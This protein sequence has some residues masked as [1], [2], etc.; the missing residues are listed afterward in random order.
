M[1]G[2]T[3]RHHRPQARRRGAEAGRECSCARPTERKDEFLATLAHE[4]RNPLAPIRNAVQILRRAARRESQADADARNDRAAGQPHGALVDDLLDV[5]RISRGMVTLRTGSRRRDRGGRR[6]SIESAAI[7]ARGHPL[8]VEM[9]GDARLARVDPLRLAQA[10]SNLLN[11]AAKYT[12]T[13]VEVA[14]T[15]E[16][17]AVITVRDNGLGLDAAEQARRLRDVLPGRALPRPQRRRPRPRPGLAQRLVECTA[18]GSSAKPRAGSGQRLH[19]AASACRRAGGV[20]QGTGHTP[21]ASASSLA[22]TGG[23]RPARFGRTMVELLKLMGH[24]VL[25]LSIGGGAVVP[26]TVRAA[27]PRLLDIGLPVLNGLQACR[28]MRHGTG[29]IA[30]VLVVVTG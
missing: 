18:D 9:P 28:L 25:T 13:M 19:R 24:E 20:R 29:L 26:R 10:L 8:R 16:E 6:D 3:F 5:S 17:E 22:R 12:D 15:Q 7:E 21:D 2:V 14:V 27:R 11:N 1:A 23:R 30:T 4:L